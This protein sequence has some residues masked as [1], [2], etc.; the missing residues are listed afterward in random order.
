MSS[1]A[2]AAADGERAHPRSVP[3]IRHPNLLAGSGI[4]RPDCMC[5]SGTSSE[6]PTAEAHVD[7]D[8]VVGQNFASY[9][10]LDGVRGIGRDTAR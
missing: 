2:T 8:T 7:T 5:F 1:A 10:N 9:L 3:A 6:L 4:P